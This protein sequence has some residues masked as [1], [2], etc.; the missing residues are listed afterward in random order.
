MV[1]L[2]KVQSN[3]VASGT[4]TKYSFPATS[5]GG[6]T[7]SF[8]IFLPSTASSSTKVPFLTYLAGLTCTEDTGAQKGGF[9]NTAAEHGIAIVFPDTSPR[10]A[11]APDEDN[12]WDFG[13]GAGFYVD[14]TAK[15]FEKY[16]MYTFLTE[17]LPKVLKE[18]DLGLVRLPSL[19]RAI[20]AAGADQGPCDED[21]LTGRTLSGSLSL[22]T[23]W[24]VR[25]DCASVDLHLAK[26]TYRPWRINA[27]S[28]QP[29]D[30]QVCL[31]IRAHL[32]RHP[33]TPVM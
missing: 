1:S 17:E 7:T 10:G 6:L 26:L 25:C 18:A 20:G 9:F 16:Q 14:A 32:V 4:V 11:G 19:S 12:D 29:P 24:V 27:V 3:K 13:T 2:E 15:G 21:K 23:L 33:R 30:L 31:C 8:N 28:P 5:L 22:G